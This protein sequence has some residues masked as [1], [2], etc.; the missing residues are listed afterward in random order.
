MYVMMQ[1]WSEMAPNSHFCYTYAGCIDGD[2]RLVGGN[3]TLEG[4]VEACHD[5]VWGTVCSD[6]WDVLDAAV[7][8]SQLGFSSSGTTIGPYSALK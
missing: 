1:L 8:C 6:F 4:R 3:S 2:I 5:G 7:V